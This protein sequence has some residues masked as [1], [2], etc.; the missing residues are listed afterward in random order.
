M[1]MQSIFTYFADPD[2]GLVN[3]VIGIIII[4]HAGKMMFTI[5]FMTKRALPT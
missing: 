1:D 2:Y 4:I 5:A 3:L